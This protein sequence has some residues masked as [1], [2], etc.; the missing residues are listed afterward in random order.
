MNIIL[1]KSKSGDAKFGHCEK[2]E[3][4]YKISSLIEILLLSHYMNNDQIT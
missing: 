4:N 1:V 2:K 3:Y